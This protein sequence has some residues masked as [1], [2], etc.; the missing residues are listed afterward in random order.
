VL[1]FKSID[2]PVNIKG[3]H[4]IVENIAGR[5]LGIWRRVHIVYDV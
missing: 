1:I 5:K 4:Y 2:Y 3:N